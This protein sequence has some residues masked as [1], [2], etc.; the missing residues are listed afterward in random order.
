MSFDNIAKAVKEAREQKGLTQ[1]QLSKSLGYDNGQFISNVERGKCSVPIKKIK[2]LAK[3]TDT[4][5][6]DF[7]GSMV[8]D[9]T[10]KLLKAV[11]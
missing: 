1:D 6:G 2:K 8:L 3:K 10:E 5:V 4:T 7:V 11:K 9:Y